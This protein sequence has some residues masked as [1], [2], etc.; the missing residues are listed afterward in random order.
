MIPFFGNL[1]AVLAGIMGFG[2]VLMA[3][4]KRKQ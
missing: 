1:I 3:I 2:G 4:H